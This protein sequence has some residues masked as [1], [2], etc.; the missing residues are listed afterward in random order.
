[1]Q[2]FQ[3]HLSLCGNKMAQDLKIGT[4]VQMGRMDVERFLTADISGRL[5]DPHSGAEAN[6]RH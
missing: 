5:R 1:M 6:G 3:Y 2:D 4:L